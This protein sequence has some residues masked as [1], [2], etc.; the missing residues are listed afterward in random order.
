MW[1]ALDLLFPIACAGCGAQGSA[2]CARCATAFQPALIRP[3]PEGVR[4]C[5]ALTAY[6]GPAG[7]ALRRAKYGGDRAAMQRLSEL[8]AAH[9]AAFAAGHDAIVPVPTP[10]FRR[11]SRGFAPASVLAA[12]LARA[13]GVPVVTALR[14]APG[15][16]QAGLDVGMRAA[17][18]AGRMRA[19]RDVPAPGRVLLVDDVLTTGATAAAAARELLGEA[20]RAVDVLVLCAVSLE[21]DRAG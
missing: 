18:L 15:R 9:G 19:R 20:T 8:A 1:G 5:A 6:D 3:A 2:W 11:L 21:A 16:R 13:S 17:N 10:W 7:D 4:L 14:M 12:E